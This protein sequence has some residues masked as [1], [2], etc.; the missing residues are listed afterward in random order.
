MLLWRATDG[1]LV[2]R[3]LRRCAGRSSGASG[4]SVFRSRARGPLAVVAQR[5]R[6]AVRAGA[7]RAADAVHIG[8]GHF[9]QFEIDD[10]AD[11]VDVDAARGDVGRDQHA[12]AAAGGNPS[13]ARMRWLWL[14][15]PWIAAAPIVGAVEMLRDAIGAALGAGEDDGARQGP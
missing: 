6:L 8:L 3:R 13:S 14:L 4:A 1:L 15:L 7:R 2:F 5:N 10:M 11:A 12:R 9:R